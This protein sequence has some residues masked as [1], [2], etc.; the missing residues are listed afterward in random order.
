VTRA[1]IV[2]G[3]PPPGYG[4][5]LGLAFDDRNGNGIPEVGEA[6]M[7]G[8]RV[9][10]EDGTVA[11]SDEQGRFSFTNVLMGEHTATLDTKKVPIEYDFL[12]DPKRKLEVKRRGIS[13][14]KFAFLI[15]GKMGGRVIEDANGNGKADEG[16]KG[17]A[18][19]LVLAALGEKKLLTYT[20]EDG[21][22]LF[23]NLRGGDY[24]LSLD[25]AS[26]PEGAG[27]TSPETLLASLPTGGELTSLNFL[28]HIR[29][30]PVIR[31]IF[32]E[33]E[34]LP[35]QELKSDEQPREENDLKQEAPAPPPEEQK[36]EGDREQAE[37]L[38]PPEEQNDEER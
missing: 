8:I 27:F 23:E 4:S 37:P 28:V 11:T 38:V 31:K 14:V 36:E 1:P 6:P 20:D 29:P 32:G 2:P 33:P 25:P 5:I 9:Q 13:K 35:E 19:A 7:R 22:Y 12:G 3:A 21:N 30:R 16:E 24:R 15:L 26:L 34:S 18:N 10:L 17:M